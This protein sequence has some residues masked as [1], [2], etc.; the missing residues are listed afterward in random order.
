LAL[1][2]R[3][4]GRIRR[5]AA[6]IALGFT[7]LVVYGFFSAGAFLAREDALVRADAIFVFA[8]TLIERPLEAADLHGAGYAPLIVVT[9]A[10]AEEATAQIEKRGV[11]IPSAFD[12]THNVLL[13]LG[14]PAEA[15][16]APDRI[17]DNTGE[18]A[19]TLRE[20]AVRR[21][22]RRVIVVS[23]KY[24][25]RRV[26]LACRRALQGTGVEIVLRGSRYDPAEPSRWWSRRSDIRWVASEL[27]KL[28]AYQLG[29]GL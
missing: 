22:W 14:I 4:H 2:A 8:G 27:P 13:Q 18:E 10:T 11:R 24:H 9:R 19:Q 1:L 15:I 6:F 16:V 17:H 25:L 20:L 21:G 29:F 3:T 12:L 28:V 23:S 26:S 5:A 7:V